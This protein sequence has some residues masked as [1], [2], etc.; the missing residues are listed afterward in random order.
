VRLALI[1]SGLGLL[2]T[3]ASLR[4]MRPDV[5][6]VLALDPEA[7][8]WGALPAGSIVER[9][10][11]S[12]RAAAAGGVDALVVPC[13]T[14]STVAL[15]VLRAEFEP[16]VPVIGTVPAV[17][18]AAALGMPFAVWATPATTASRYQ[19]ELVHRFAEGLPVEHVACT[20]LAEAIEAADE[21][22]IDAALTRAVADTSSACAAVVLGC[23][24]YPLVRD[25]IAARLPDTV[26]LLDSAEAVARQTL[27][28]LAAQPGQPNGEEPG[29]GHGRTTVLLSGRPGELPAAAGAYAE[30]RALL[31]S[32]LLG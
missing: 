21:A 7:M 17:K 22:R 8:P 32:G 25:A 16:R 3:A 20:D 11:L 31:R 18:P 6:L 23:T 13:N 9:L 30:G 4:R 24:H 29:K 26:V 14:A 12:A 27:R 10:L 2:P 19:A 15:E 1:D 28:R 5:D